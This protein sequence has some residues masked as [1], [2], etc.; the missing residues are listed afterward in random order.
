MEGKN[1]IQLK[2]VTKRFGKVIANDNI[3]LSVK[4]GEIL[5]I[6]GENG[7]G[8][9]TLM[10]MISGIYFPDEGEIFIDGR[11]VAIRSPKDA[12]SLGIGMVHQHFKLINVLSAAENIILG[13]PGSGRLNME[14][15]EKEIKDLSDRYGFELKPYQKIYD[16]SVS[17][18]QTVEII[19]VLYRGADILILDEPTAVLTPQ[20]TEKLFSVLRN[21]RAAG[22]SIIIITHKLNE[23]LE[24]SDR[25]SVLR[26]GKYIGT[27][28]T[29]KATVS[30][31][32]EMMVGERVS[33]NIE[34][35]KP[36]NPVE[37]L[38]IKNLTCINSDGIKTLNNVS[39]TANGGEILGIAGIAGSG[40]KELLEAIT[41]LQD[42][43]G[44]SIIYKSTEGMDIELLGIKASDI[45][46]SG[47]KISFVPEDRLGMGLVA[48]MGMTDNMMLRS[49]NKENRFFVDRKK[50]RELAHS[51]I[52]KLSVVTPGTETPVG[53]L[54]GGNVQKVLVGREI[55]N[56]PEILILAY[57]VRGLDI[58][59]SYTIYNLM[60]EQKKKGVAVICVIEDLDVLIELC[61]KIVV[62]NS[63]EVSGILDA[64]KTNKE[65]VG[66]LMTRHRME[67]LKDA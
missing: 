33:L 9:T 57:P 10:N 7:S 55:A 5:S 37:K 26:K 1:A 42:L 4:K 62:L 56:N 18:K 24:L 48:S 52:E 63:G 67:E 23:V 19:K 41:G 11:E 45:E 3:N 12:F 29:N 40:Q 28:D 6:L 51:I 34:R 16:M 60:N 30:S 59:S 27:V 47:I 49:Y 50:P 36:E 66:L 38:Q 17:E 20:E 25:V 15:V 43:E 39:L 8:K 44:G 64:R 2:N 53:R 35:N 14:Q 22:K 13:M 21:M 54:S 61:D 46:K 65:E 32:T 58:N 31:L